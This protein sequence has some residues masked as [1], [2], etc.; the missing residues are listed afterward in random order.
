M[1]EKCRTEELKKVQKVQKPM[2]DNFETWNDVIDR[3]N[4]WHDAYAQLQQQG[5]VTPEALAELCPDMSDPHTWIEQERDWE[6]MVD[7][8]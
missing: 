1:A 6:N 7:R 8:R 4:K 5:N 2:S 3:N